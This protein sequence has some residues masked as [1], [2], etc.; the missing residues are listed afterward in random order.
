MPSDRPIMENLG[1]LCAWLLHLM[2]LPHESH[3]LTK[4]N[5]LT[6]RDESQSREFLALV[7]LAL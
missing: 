1:V 7:F 4:G 5:F 2:P 3:G 6:I